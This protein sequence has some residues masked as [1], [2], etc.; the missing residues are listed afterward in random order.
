MVAMR[1]TNEQVVMT[2][3][4]TVAGNMIVDELRRSGVIVEM[5]DNALIIEAARDLLKANP[6]IIEEARRVMKGKG[7]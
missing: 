6:E 4:M 1:I 2:R 5:V 3:A 7:Q